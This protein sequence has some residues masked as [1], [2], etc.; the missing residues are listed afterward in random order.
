MT[1]ETGQNV[2]Q[3]VHLTQWSSDSRISSVAEHVVASCTAIAISS[4]RP[5]P[6]RRSSMRG[7]HELGRAV[8]GGRG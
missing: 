6:A 4:S 3:I 2:S 7:E 8:A 5:R 1:F